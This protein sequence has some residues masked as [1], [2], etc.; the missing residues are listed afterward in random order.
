MNFENLD[1]Q[2][3]LMIA[4]LELDGET[5]GLKHS[6][7]DPSENHPAINYLCQ[8][9][10]DQKIGIEFQQLQVPICEE[11][12]EAL[13]DTDWILAYCTNCLK[14]QWIYRPYSKVYHPEGN[15]IYWMDVCPF[16][17][18][19]ANEYEEKE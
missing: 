3:N 13:S 6:E 15:G 16:C 9:I 4:R 11:C 17:A 2:L 5:C 12:T 1:E 10:G 8:N 18:E 19:V 14:S 7:Q